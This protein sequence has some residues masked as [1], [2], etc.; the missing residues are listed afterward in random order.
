M[1][2]K[3]NR[4]NYYFCMVFFILF[5]INLIILILKRFVFIYFNYSYLNQ[6]KKMIRFKD[7]Q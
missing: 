7:L 6:A 4:I 5:F 2:Y 1:S 3:Y